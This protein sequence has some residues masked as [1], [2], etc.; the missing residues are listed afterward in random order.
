MSS[1]AGPR[2]RW[3]PWMMLGLASLLLVGSVVLVVSGL[4]QSTSPVAGYPVDRAARQSA[5]DGAWT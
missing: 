2:S 5:L 4:G 1:R 3:L